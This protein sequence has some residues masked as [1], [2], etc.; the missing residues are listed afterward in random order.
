VR[1]VLW[2]L[3]LLAPAQASVPDLSVA[4][5]SLVISEIMAS[6]STTLADEDGDYEDWIELRNL[7]TRL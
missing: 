5:S 1:K 7:T 2:A 6:N 4:G 3:V